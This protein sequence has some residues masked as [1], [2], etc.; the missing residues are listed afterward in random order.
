MADSAGTSRAS[1]GR[2]IL[3]TV[4]FVVWAPLSFA[5]LP[6]AA[7]MLAAHPGRGPE[8][9]LAALVGVP[10]IG[11]VALSSGSLLGAA[12]QT[13]LV[14]F[15]AAFVGLT[16]MAPTSFL[17]QAL[18]ASLLAFGAGLMLARLT[19]GAS[20]APLLFWTAT[21]QA[22]EILRL[23]VQQR[24]ELYIVF[25]PAARFFSA[26]LPAS[27]VL[28]GIA[29]LALAWRW[30]E[31]LA[32]TPLGAPLAPFREFRF[33]DGWV[34]GIVGAIVIWITPVLAGLKA[35]A[36]NLIVLLGALYLLRGAA[37]VVAFAA[38]AGISPAA[39]TIALAV[40]ALLTLPLL[41]L[42]PGLA[43]LGVTDTWLEFRRRLASGP[44]HDRG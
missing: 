13:Y 40:S 3:A 7:L 8:R 14:L 9:R 30:H 2:L 21:R 11:L 23:A 20:A 19:L 41:F 18:R 35:A 12:A 15:T 44:A 4:A 16:L 34:W 28:Q 32:R 22:N 42:L 25:E 10:S 5:P 1:R 43:T 38:V 37:I 39:L 36:L 26:T 6:F 17:R 24:P 33:S 27:L 31:Q 29:G